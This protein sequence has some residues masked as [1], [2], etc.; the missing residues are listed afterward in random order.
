MRRLA[1]GHFAVEDNLDYISDAMHR[2]YATKVAGIRTAR[3][4][5]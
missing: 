4:G 1:A 2:F 3:A 5:H